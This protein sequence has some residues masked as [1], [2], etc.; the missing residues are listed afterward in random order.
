MF[1]LLLH[2]ISRAPSTSVR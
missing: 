1:I 2:K